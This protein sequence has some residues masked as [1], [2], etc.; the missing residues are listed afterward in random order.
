MNRTHRSS[1]NLAQVGKHDGIEWESDYG[2]EDHEHPTERAVR[3][4]V[5]VS[6]RRYHREN[7]VEGVIE[8]PDV[9]SLVLVVLGVCNREHA[10]SGDFLEHRLD[11]R[12]IVG[13]AV[14][15]VFCEGNAGDACLVVFGG[16]RNLFVAL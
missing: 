16:K 7:E 6:N 2:V 8:S 9:G 3:G 5:T 10:V 13:Q 14:D 12:F 4:D 1:E 15:Q 11:F